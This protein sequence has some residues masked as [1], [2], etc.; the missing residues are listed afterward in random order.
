MKKLTLI[1][2]VF[3][4]VQGYA[5]VFDFCV[6]DCDIWG[7]PTLIG[8]ENGEELPGNPNVRLIEEYTSPDFE[9]KMK[10]AIDSP[11]DNTEDLIVLCAIWANVANTGDKEL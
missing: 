5:R 1:F 8:S 9:L 2:F 6:S 7:K 11:T 4:C 10:A 3:F